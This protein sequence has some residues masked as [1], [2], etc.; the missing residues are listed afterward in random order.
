[1]AKVI[2]S[3]AQSLAE[4]SE[5]EDLEAAKNKLAYRLRSTVQAYAIQQKAVVVD[6]GTII[7]G[8][9]RDITEEVINEVT[10]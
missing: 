9:V 1:M 2:R 10:R 4:A 5:G 8:E 6:S 7:S 3:A